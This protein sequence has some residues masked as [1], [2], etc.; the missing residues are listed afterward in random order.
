M[1]N[2]FQ[3]DRKVEKDGARRRHRRGCRLPR[4]ATQKEISG[5]LPVLLAS[6]ARDLPGSTAYAAQ[7][8]VTTAHGSAVPLC[9]WH[10]PHAVSRRAG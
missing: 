4:N 6:L 8:E 7:C 5:G 9:C 1:A 2:A 10:R 3:L